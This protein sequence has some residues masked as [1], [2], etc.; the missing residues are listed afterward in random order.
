MF[1][2]VGLVILLTQEQYDVQFHPGVGGPNLIPLNFTRL[3]FRG[4][5][6]RFCLVVQ[7]MFLERAFV[8]NTGLLDCVRLCVCVCLE[9]A[10]FL[11]F[12][13]SG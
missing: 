4:L 12:F 1:P 13:L 5:G 3:L 6:F 8:F 10:V 11:C 2:H 7:F 9:G